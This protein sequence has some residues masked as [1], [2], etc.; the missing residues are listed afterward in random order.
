MYQEEILKAI[1][2]QT[3]AIERLIEAVE[4]QS[5]SLE[6]YALNF[7]Q[8]YGT[9]LEKAAPKTADIKDED[10]KERDKQ[11]WAEIDAEQRAKRK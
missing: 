2:E 8:A 6:W 9:D 4:R 7:G 5:Q 10:L 3:R 11:L 1:K